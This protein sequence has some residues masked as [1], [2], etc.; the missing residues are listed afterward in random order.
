MKKFLV[1]S[2]ALLI[3]TAAA[4]YVYTSR[5]TQL[6]FL[7]S[8]QS[9][10]VIEINGKE[11]KVEIADSSQER[12]KGLGGRE[13]LASDSGMLF[14]FPDKGQYSFWMKGLKF[15]LDLIWIRDDVVVDI[16]ENVPSP[17]PNQQDED[18]PIYQSRIEVDKVL[19]VNAGVVERFQ[20]K[21]GDKIILK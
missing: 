8:S 2:I 19:E 12:S 10:D 15:P 20:I 18:L 7:P 1:Q 14:I 21:V 16:I 11:I 9:L 6:P 5:V 3:V 17:R 4:F 13:S